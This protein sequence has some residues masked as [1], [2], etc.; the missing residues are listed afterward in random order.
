MSNYNRNSDDFHIFRST[1]YVIAS[2]GLLAYKCTNLI[3]IF[4]VNVSSCCNTGFTDR[5]RFTLLTDRIREIAHCL[6][7]SYDTFNYLYFD[8]ILDCQ[9]NILLYV[10]IISYESHRNRFVV[11]FISN[12]LLI[13]VGVFL[14]LTCE[15]S[16][17]NYH[18]FTSSCVRILHFIS[19][20]LVWSQFPRM[21]LSV[22]KRY[23]YCA[24]PSNDLLN[25]NRSILN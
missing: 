11:W 7:N 9:S 3:W 10:L 4:L 25:R 1:L 2:R 15:V 17:V 8:R 18:L 24:S 21:Y 5:S 23:S 22:S 6:L 20:A 13:T 12:Y 16:V 19:T 14:S